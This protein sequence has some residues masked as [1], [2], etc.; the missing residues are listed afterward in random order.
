SRPARIISITSNS[1]WTAT[2]TAYDA[3]DNVIGTSVLTHPSPGSYLLLGTLTVHTTQPIA[4][5]SIL[6]DN[7][8]L[9]LNLDDLHFGSALAF[10]TVTPCRLVDT[11]AAS[12]TFGGPALVAGTDRVFPLYGRCG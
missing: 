4:R 12:G 10:F 2:L 7:P 6:P 11:R 8:D 1:Y 5:F 3:S 9:I